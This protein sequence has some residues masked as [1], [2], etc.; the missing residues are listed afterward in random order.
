MEEAGGPLP[1]GWPSGGGEPARRSE[2]R[3]D[4]GTAERTGGGELQ[5]ESVTTIGQS[6]F[7]GCAFDSIII[8]KPQD[9]ISGSPWGWSGGAGNVTWTGSTPAAL[10]RRKEDV[11]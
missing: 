6:A 2:V 7:H 10:P 5:P 3:G 11:S 9:F 4:P 1:G 8:N